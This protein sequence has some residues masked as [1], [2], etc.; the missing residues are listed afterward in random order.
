MIATNRHGMLDCLKGKLIVS[1]Q[2]EVGEPFDEP[3]PFIAMCRSVLDGGASALRLANPTTI[4]WARET[5]GSEL[6]IIGLTKPRP[7]PPDAVSQV[8]ITPTWADAESLIDA[9]V[10]IVAMD[11]TD[12]PRPDGESLASIVTRCKRNYPDIGLMADLATLEDGM[13][14]IDLGF[15]VLST[16][17]AGYTAETKDTATDDPD[18]ALLEG[19]VAL[20]KN[21]TTRTP[22][23]LEGRVWDPGQVTEGFRRG[24]HCVVIGSAITRPHYI[25]RRFIQA[26]PK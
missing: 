20:S 6:P 7:I 9:G 12:R 16:T 15:D 10:N 17:L 4:R 5:F 3:E 19:L 21:K 26:L 25:T 11:A 24:A 1:V 2:A 23:I 13:H 14:A 18:W 8:Y 22:V